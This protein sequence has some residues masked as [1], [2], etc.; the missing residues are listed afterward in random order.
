MLDDLAA[1]VRIP[2]LTGDE[3]AA[4]EF[5][6]ER[7]AALGLEADLHR[8]DLAAL[9]AH[10]GHP[11][12]EAP[13]EEL[14]G[15][16]LTRPGAGRRI[17]L[18][19]HVDVVDPGTEAW[20]H[21]DPFSAEV[22]DGFLYGRGSVDMKAG[23]MASL[24]AMAA[25]PPGPEIVLQVVGSEE[26]GGLGTFAALE[27]DAA[28]DA[29]LITE[30]TGWAVVAAQAGALTFRGVI[31]G[32]SAHAAYRLEGESAIDTYVGIHGRIAELERTIN[33]RVDHPLMQHLELPY[34]VQVG[35]IEG[36]RWSAS[37]PDEV[38]FHGRLGVA[39]GTPL[40]RA[41][42]DLEAA[43]APATITWEGGAYGW[44]D[45]DPGHPWVEQVRAAAEA[46]LGRPVPV[47]G[48][49]W[50]ADMRLFTDRGIP[51]TM[52]G[53][54]GIERAH[55]VDERVSLQE[56]ESLR[57]VI[58]RTLTVAKSNDHS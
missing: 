52:L 28:F 49:P 40:D 27:R 50:G 12:E 47:T 17:C 36:G 21:G 41:R 1:L 54:S 58:L 38:V 22:E 2:S 20:R 11:G 5:L 45:T 6:A 48:V 7:G 44:A 9:R 53:T 39:V 33:A 56:V 51:A 16:T 8:H 55:A 23:V 13:R 3:R 18:N 35:R 19:G 15:L 34:A 37:V 30:P 57:R 10:P 31:H 29:A 43:A 32:R 42:A 4:M 25:A 46:E 24:H 14:W 26:D